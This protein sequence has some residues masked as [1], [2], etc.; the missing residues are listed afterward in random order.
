MLVINEYVYLNVFLGQL[1][2]DANRRCIYNILKHIAF[3]VLKLC[4]NLKIGFQ[5][6]HLFTDTAVILN[7]IVSNSYY[8]MP[9]GTSHNFSQY[10]LKR[11]PY[12]YKESIPKGCLTIIGLLPGFCDVTDHVTITASHKSFFLHV[13]HPT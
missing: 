10:K 2:L 8:G 12:R 9:R 1:T 7:S 13:N 6:I 11:L 4:N 3:D 5:L